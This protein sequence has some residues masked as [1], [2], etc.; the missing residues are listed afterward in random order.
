MP[1]LQDDTFF[2]E[3][4]VVCFLASRGVDWGEGSGTSYPPLSHSSVAGDVGPPGHRSSGLRTPSG[5]RSTMW[6]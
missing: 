1:F 2:A 4:R 6:V 5:P 3:Y